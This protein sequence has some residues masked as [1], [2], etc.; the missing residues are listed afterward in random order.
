M[1]QETNSPVLDADGKAVRAEVS[2]TAEKKDGTVELVFELDAGLLAGKTVVAFED[3]YHNDVKVAAHADIEDEEQSVHYPEVWTEA[4]DGQTQDHVGT[5]QKKAVIH[6]EVHCENLTA[7]KEY[8]IK[9]T[10]MDKDTGKEILTSEGTYISL[11]FA[12]IN[13]T[14]G[15]FDAVVHLYSFS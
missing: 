4:A 6:D 11:G 14:P 8:T 1:N 10:L 5:E 9:G 7:G 3:L 15:A 13:G 2:F 12:L